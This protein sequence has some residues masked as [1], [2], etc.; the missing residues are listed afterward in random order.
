MKIQKFLWPRDQGRIRHALEQLPV[1]L[2]T[3]FTITITPHD[4][5]SQ[6]QKG[7]YWANVVRRIAENTGN[8]EDSVHEHLKRKFLPPTQYTFNGET[9]E[10]L[11]TTTRLLKDGWSTYITRCEAWA[12][13]EGYL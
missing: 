13:G 1:R 10:G 7:Y 6:E 12:A 4:P 3:F 5:A 11:P 9:L 2:G 8:D